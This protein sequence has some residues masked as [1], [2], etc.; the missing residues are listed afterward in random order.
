VL[1]HARRLKMGPV[2]RITLIFR[3]R[4]WAKLYVPEAPAEVQA[5]LERL[6]FC[7]P[8]GRLP[9]WWTPMPQTEAMITAWVAGPRA[10]LMQDKRRRLEMPTRCWRC[11]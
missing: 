7:S 1:T 11:A 8:T 10:L 6:S 5:G 4:F 2:L 9:D 3:K